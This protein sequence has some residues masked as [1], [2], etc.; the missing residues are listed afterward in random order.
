VIVQKKIRD[1]VR[2]ATEVGT[3]QRIVFEPALSAGKQATSSGNVA[4]KEK[5]MEKA[6]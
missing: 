4:L 3:L 5:E 6:T 2:N 1:G